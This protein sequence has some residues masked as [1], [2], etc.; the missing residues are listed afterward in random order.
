MISADYDGTGNPNNFTWTPLVGTLSPGGWAWTPS[1]I[2][3]VA[4]TNGTGVH[5]AFK[6]TST[7][8]ESATWEVDEVL[9]TGIVLVGI[10]QT[11]GNK[12]FSVMPNPSHGK[13]NVVF[14]DNSQKEVQIISV[15][16]KEIFKANTSQS[17]FSVDIPDLTPG[18]YFV[19]VTNAETSVVMTK[20]IMIQ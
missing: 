4:G 20:K 10:P 16:G 17:N 6:F 9:T 19:R 14:D 3:N 1:G 8:T 11:N 12:E 2:V 15:I 5:I 18:I 13:F 7:D